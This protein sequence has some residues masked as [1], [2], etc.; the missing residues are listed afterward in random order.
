MHKSEAHAVSLGRLAA[1]KEPGEEA[2]ELPAQLPDV[3]DALK[4]ATEALAL[5]RL[6]EEALAD[7]QQA[8]L[9]TEAL[10]WRELG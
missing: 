6:S 10:E 8:L 9:A 5:A 4:A 3:A 7:G 2:R 1:S